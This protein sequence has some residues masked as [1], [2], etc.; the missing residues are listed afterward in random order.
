MKRLLIIVVLGSLVAGGFLFMASAA[1]ATENEGGIKKNSF[2]KKASQKT[3]LQ[4]GDII[5]Q[6]SKSGQSHAIQLAT[7]SKYSHVGI[8]FQQ[9]GEWIVLEAVQPVKLTPLSKW[10]KH[11]DDEAYEVK[12]LKNAEEL[13]TLEAKERMTSVGEYML[14]KNYDIYFDW[15]DDE[16]YCSELVWK[17]YNEALGVELGK[18]RPLKDFNLESPIVRQIMKQR[19]GNDIPLD[20]KMI[21]PGDMFDSEELEVVIL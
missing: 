17:I 3:N 15:S 12:R 16:I 19:Y 7:G 2:S 10:K 5:F 14:G 11:G 4:F 13:I 21:S 18:L 8:L 1:S 6:S 20:S 9:K